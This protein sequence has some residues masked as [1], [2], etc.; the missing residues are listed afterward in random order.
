MYRFV[1]L[2]R[3]PVRWFFF[4]SAL[5]LNFWILLITLSSGKQAFSACSLLNSTYLSPCQAP[6]IWYSY[7]CHT[8][9]FVA[10]EA[11]H[12][13]L[14]NYSFVL[15]LVFDRFFHGT[16]YSELQLLSLLICGAIDYSLVRFDIPALWRNPCLLPRFATYQLRMW[17]IGE[18]CFT[19]Y[20]LH[21]IDI[22]N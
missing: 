15:G 21:G 12:H 16:L 10:M 7:N 4:I 17:P 6:F 8:L 3:S 14:S 5:I 19:R 20:L 18:S 1:T 2:L 22:S 11:L 13:P 9:F